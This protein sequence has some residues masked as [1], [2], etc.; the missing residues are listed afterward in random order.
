MLLVFTEGGEC[1]FV[2]VVVVVVFCLL[3]L[4]VCFACLYYLVINCLTYRVGDMLCVAVFVFFLLLPNEC[5]L[6][7]HTDSSISDGGLTL[8]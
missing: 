4:F 6:G 7:V 2:V 3:F 8:T 1:F 5:P